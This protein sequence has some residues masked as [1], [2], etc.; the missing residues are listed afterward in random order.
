MPNFLHSYDHF[1]KYKKYR[2]CRDFSHVR[3][4][5][6]S[7][8]YI[9]LKTL[10]AATPRSDSILEKHL[11]ELYYLQ[12]QPNLT[13]NIFGKHRIL[14]NG[15]IFHNKAYLNLKGYKSV[16]FLTPNKH[17]NLA[18]GVPFNLKITDLDQKYAYY[19]RNN[20]AKIQTLNYKDVYIYPAPKWQTCQDVNFTPFNWS[21]YETSRITTYA[22]YT[23]ILIRAYKLLLTTAQS[24]FPQTKVYLK[25]F[26]HL[27]NR[28]NTGNPQNLS[29]HLLTFLILSVY[30]LYSHLVSTHITVQ[31]CITKL[32]TIARTRLVTGLRRLQLA[33]ENPRSEDKSGEMA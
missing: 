22:T 8:Q 6:T 3:S 25:A 10:K 26:K 2:L 29:F 18:S 7:L 31:N 13:S 5:E 21:L 1:L 23:E 19:L 4:R 20:P 15:T 12:I 16:L 30:E 9:N 33:W 27:N 14:R 11:R 24:E 28:Q 17:R 32:H